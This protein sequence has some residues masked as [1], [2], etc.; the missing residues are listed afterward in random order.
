MVSLWPSSDGENRIEKTYSEFGVGRQLEV[1][2]TVHVRDCTAESVFEHR[3]EWG[4]LSGGGEGRKEGRTRRKK[5]E[6]F[7][8]FFLSCPLCCSHCCVTSG[9]DSAAKIEMG[10]PSPFF[11]LLFWASSTFFFFF[12]FPSST[13]THNY[14]LLS[15]L[16]CPFRHQPTL[17][18]PSSTPTC[19]HRYETH[20]SKRLQLQSGL[21]KTT[22][23][24]S[25]VF[26]HLMNH[27]GTKTSWRLHLAHQDPYSLTTLSLSLSLLRPQLVALSV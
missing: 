22:T 23:I 13:H 1:L 21:G 15:S 20:T 11:R 25:F 12:F 16:P 14:L 18:F 6:T 19:L 5:K 7:R 8:L 4:M 2:A 3:C 24:L 27:T 9:T 17:P 26:I 10:G